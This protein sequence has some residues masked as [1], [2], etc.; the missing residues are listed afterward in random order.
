MGELSQ[1]DLDCRGWLD[2]TD[3]RAIIA[4]LISRT[5]CNLRGGETRAEGDAK[6]SAVRCGRW[7]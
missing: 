5:K 7:A 1:A 3:N 4:F 6:G 2:V